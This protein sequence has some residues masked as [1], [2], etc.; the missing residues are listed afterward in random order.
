MR[1]AFRRDVALGRYVALDTALH[2]LDARTKLVGFAV[3]LAALFA[4]GPVGTGLL[5]LGLGAATG[6]AGL[7]LRRV[8]AAIRSLAW[9]LALTVLFQALWIGP[10]RLGGVG[11]GTAAGLHLAVRLVGMV[12]AATLLTWTTEP[13]RL[14]DGMARTFRF[15]ERIRVPVRDLAMVLTLSLRFLPT[16]MEEAERLVTAQR[17][18]GARFEGGPLTR[19]RRLLPLAVPLFTGCLQRADRLALAMEVRGWKAGG[20]RT[21]LDPPAF[22]AADAW[23]MAILAFL[24]ALVWLG[25]AVAGGATAPGGGA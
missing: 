9:I 2:R 21:Q 13:I 23:A 7:P 10:S 5:V 1:F 24:A 3:V 20:E 14:A 16:V 15:L 11:A 12:L 17:A 6:A 25:P 19:A 8:G 18:R 4:T 22:R